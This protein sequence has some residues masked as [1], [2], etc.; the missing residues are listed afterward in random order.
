MDYTEIA[1]DVEQM[2]AC[3]RMNLPLSVNHI[4][5]KVGVITIE[6][7]PD[8]DCVDGKQLR[9]RIVTFDRI[10]TKIVLNPRTPFFSYT[11]VNPITRNKFKFE[12]EPGRAIVAVEE[13]AM[14]NYI[15]VDEEEFLRE[16]MKMF[17]LN[18]FNIARGAWTHMM[19]VDDSCPC[20]VTLLRRGEQ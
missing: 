17:S 6:S 7:V 14:C 10:T 16:K 18:W 9:I 3:V 11:E 20:D 2:A 1:D 19:G 5:P 15:R 8:S 13:G 4:H 12:S